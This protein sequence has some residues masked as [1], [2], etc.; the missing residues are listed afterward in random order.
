MKKIKQTGLKKPNFLDKY[1][2]N[3]YINISNNND[4]IENINSKF[5]YYQGVWS[6]PKRRALQ[7]KIFKLITDRVEYGLKQKNA[8]AIFKKFF[9]H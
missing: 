4:Y 1:N 8:R 7:N 5:I 9:V 3:K 6:P 2:D